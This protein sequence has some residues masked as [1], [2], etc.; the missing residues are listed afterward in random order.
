MQDAIINSITAIINISDS[1]DN[2]KTGIERHYVRGTSYQS[3]HHV[4]FNLSKQ[5]SVSQK[6]T[7]SFL[8][9]NITRTYALKQYYCTN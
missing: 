8:H 7:R 9:V 4:E 3:R 1:V 2:E 6:S 5:R